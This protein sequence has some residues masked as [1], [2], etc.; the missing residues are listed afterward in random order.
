MPTSGQDI[1]QFARTRADVLRALG[2]DV[3]TKTGVLETLTVSRSTLDR[4]VRDLAVVGLVERVDG[5]V[6]RTLPGTLTLEEYDRY[7]DRLESIS[8]AEPVL[9]PLDADAPFDPRVLDGAT[10]VPA[11]RLTPED[12]LDSLT[13]LVVDATEIRAF[14]PVVFETQV[15]AYH[16][17]LVDD[18][19]RARVVATPAVVERLISTHAEELNAALS[20]GRLSIREAPALPYGLTVVDTPEGPEMGMLVYDDGAVCGFVHNTSAAAV[21][22]AHA[23]V[24]ERWREADPIPYARDG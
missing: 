2:S 6:R 18:D 19:A 22:W 10:V 15:E 8:E 9:A 13:S 20:T 4:A 17:A 21:E 3:R 1:A 16:R 14:T 24:T 7:T 11:T 23:R 5:G 12:P